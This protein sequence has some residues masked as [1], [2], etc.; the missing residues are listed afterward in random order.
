MH[1]ILLVV[2]QGKRNLVKKE[3]YD[4]ENCE[5]ILNKKLRYNNIRKMSR[6][7]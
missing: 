2:V 3:Q 1:T 5:I 6:G 4:L 7:S